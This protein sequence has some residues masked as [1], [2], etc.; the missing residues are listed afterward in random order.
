P[1]SSACTDGGQP[2]LSPNTDK[3]SIMPVT[4]GSKRTVVGAHYG[5]RDWIV[6]RA[7]A[8]IITLFTLAVLAQLL[9][10]RGPIGYDVWA[11]IF[12]SQ[13]MKTLTFAV[14]VALAWHAWVGVRNVWMDYVKPAGL[15]E[16]L[17]VLSIAWL[18]ACAG[19]GVQV[20]WRL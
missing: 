16:T 10:T 11:G 14:I 17:H 3:E 8:V 2:L 13:W 19:W 6:Q 5:V 9:F 1:S 7:T 20:L 18:V 12:S 15:R 4:Y